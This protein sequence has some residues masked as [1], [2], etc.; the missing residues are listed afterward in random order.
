[1]SLDSKIK[2]QL[3]QHLAK[4]SKNIEIFV[5][6]GDDETSFKM[7]DLLNEIKDLSPH[8]S[9][10]KSELPKLPSFSINQP[11]DNTGIVFAGIPMGHEFT[12]LILAILQVGGYPLK[13]SNDLIDQIKK[14]EG[15]FD[16]E[17][18]ISLSCHNCPDLVQ[19]LNLLALLNPNISH[20]MI[21]GALFQD[22]VSA[23]NIMSVPTILLN[24]EK[25]GQ[26]RMELEEII[27]K[28]DSSAK[29]KS[30]QKLNKQKPFDVLIVGGG[31][32]GASA[33]V[34][35]ARKG[36]RTGIVAER[37]GGQVMDTLGIENFISVK[38]TEGPKLVSA[39]EE[40]VKEYEVDIF[41]LQK[42]NKI[43]KNENSLRSIAFKDLVSL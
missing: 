24:G 4:I 14:I 6:A 22:E 29:E 21:D 41:N 3:K 35:S 12:S 32:A 33:A 11:G 30:A 8:I 20:T 9:L 34:Y 40:H 1:M 26:G 42:A 15:H 17:T 43:Y 25:F 39:L 27:N 5:N 10:K 31:P 23:K 28:I 18:Y 36:I 2:E 38:A 19:A 13:I 7:I 37:F 16:F